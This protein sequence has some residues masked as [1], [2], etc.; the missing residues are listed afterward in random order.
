MQLQT[1]VYRSERF[2]HQR[3]AEK[4]VKDE[5]CMQLTQQF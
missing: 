2:I 4:L 3:G 5:L 1:Q